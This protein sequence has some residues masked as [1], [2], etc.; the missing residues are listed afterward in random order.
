MKKTA[1]LII[2]VMLV[3]LSV[4]AQNGVVRE[5][6]GTVEL[7]HS[8]AS[9]FTAAKNGDA[10]AQDTV[11]S[12]GFK[13]TALVEVGSTVIALRPLTRLTLKEI[14]ASAGA[15]TLNVDLQAGRVR[16]DV[17]PPAGTKASMSI[18][19]PSATASVRGTSFDMDVVSVSVVEGGVN[20]G[21]NRGSPSVT[22]QESYTVS[23]DETGKASNAVYVFTGASNTS[24]NTGT[25]GQSGGFLPSN[26]G[27]SD[28]SLGSQTIAGGST[29][30]TPPPS[31]TEPPT[32]PPPTT[33]PPTTEPPP[34][35]T[36]PPPSVPVPPPVTVTPPFIP[37]TT[38]TP[39][40]TQPSTGDVTIG[41]D[42]N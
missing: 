30:T 11:V 33:P 37:P 21:D 40:P 1:M 2:M 10:I 42:Y 29:P 16:V 3:S 32:T 25:S 18:S 23:V 6:N 36:P 34:S 20:Y 9:G 8:G 31:T 24:V 17:N 14:S 22:V 28:S 12:T 39:P 5:I 26:P 4:F 19:S 41:I 13:S 15:E 7:K 35:T 27:G 38:P